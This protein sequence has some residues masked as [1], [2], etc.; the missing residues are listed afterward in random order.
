MKQ[1]LLVTALTGAL[2]VPLA[3]GRQNAPAAEPARKKARKPRPRKTP[4]PQATPTKAIVYKKTKDA[5]GEAVEL[6]LHVFEPDG[7]KASDKRSAIVFFFGG[8]WVGGNPRQFFQ[9]CKY[10]ASRGM[11]AASA[12]YRVRGRHGTTPFE[13]VADGKSAVRYIRANA[14]KLGVDPKRIAAGGGSAGGHV[15]ACTGTVKGLDE[16]SEDAAVSSRPDAMVLFNP[17]IYCGPDGGYG[18]SRLKDRWK[19]ISPVMN[20]SKETPPTILFHGKADTTVKYA[21]AEKFAQAM[22]EAGRRCEL[23]GLEGAK[24]GFFNYGRDG[25]AAYVK[26]VRAADTFLASLGFLKGKPTLEPPED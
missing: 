5:K 26:T 9:H 4:A 24:H 22:K 16:K 1:I 15:A 10:L 2:L 18:F 17:V 21:N 20:V 14:E 3:H 12:E 23:V 8:G 7:H 13:C 11:W 25:G 6:K 19:D